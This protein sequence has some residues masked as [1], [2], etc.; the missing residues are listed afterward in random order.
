MSDH[1]LRRP[2]LAEVVGGTLDRTGTDPRRL[3]IEITETLAMDAALSRVPFEQLV[4]RGVAL[5]IDDFGIG[6]SSLASL[7]YFPASV[8]KLDQSLTA[9]V[10]QRTDAAAVTKAAI[11]MGHALDLAVLAE[12]VESA[13][14]LDTL[15]LL[16]CDCG[17]GWHLGM[18]ALPEEL[19][20]A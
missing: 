14:H 17:Q 19:A 6:Y 13:E 7:R 11:D 15:H 12:G 10:A 20:A 18:P 4:D 3:G 9:D 5:A 16:D 1:Q 8:L 2:D